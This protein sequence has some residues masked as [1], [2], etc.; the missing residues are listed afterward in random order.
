LKK[1]HGRM[2]S[3]RRGFMNSFARRTGTIIKQPLRAVF[4][5]ALGIVLLWTILT[6]SLPYVLAPAQTSLAL[7]LSSNNPAA[8]MVKAE[9]LERRYMVLISEGTGRPGAGRDEVEE[10]ST[11][12]LSKL[13]MVRAGESAAEP[14][15]ERENLREE[16]RSLARQI[17]ANDPLN[18]RAFRLLAEVTADTSQVRLLMQQSLL[19]SR[20][21]SA[22]AFWLLNDSIYHRNFKAALGYA[23]IL[24]RTC[25]QLAPYVVNNLS[26]IADDPEGRGLLAE[27]LA[28]GPEWR[29]QFFGALPRNAKRADTPLELMTALQ[30][31]GKPVSQK[32]I[33]PYLDF[34]VG[35]G[36]ADLAYNAWLQFLPESKLER[37]SYLSNANFENAP[38]GL[39]FD[40]RIAYGVNAIAE[41]VPLQG[42]GTQHALH[43][44]FGEGRVKFPDVSQIVLLASGHFRLEGKLRGTIAG[45]RGLRWQLRCASGARRVLAETEMLLG[46]SR[47]WRI[48]T[49]DA[50][51]PLLEDCRGQ[52]LRLFHDSRMAS[53]E[54]LSG[55]VWFSDL[56]LEHAASNA[57]AKKAHVSLP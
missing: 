35:T 28:T 18:A 24:L 57:A 11:N 17:I 47:E 29:E 38:S 21:E 51:V 12:T 5:G 43:I 36:R 15:E 14:I 10:G 30:D 40:W 3:R 16:I 55:E 7:A 46:Q 37:V 48:F 26:L 6:K 54:L 20:R 33:A 56:R 2:G 49:L 25:P 9:A 22:A 44:R 52:V 23:D 13:P 8:L 50:E 41:I 31:A 45:K 1:S 27:V 42:S 53:E 34:L 32:E 19:R 39:P 4:A